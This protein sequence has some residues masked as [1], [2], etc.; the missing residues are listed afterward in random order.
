MKKIIILIM[1]IFLVS[2]C[3]D[4]EELNNINIVTGIGFDKEDDEYLVTLEITKSMGKEQNAEKSST[5]FE[6][7]DKILEIAINK[8]INNSDKKAYFKHTNIILISE[9][10]AKDGISNII[11]Y[12]LRDGNMSTTYFT[13][14]CENASEILKMELEND[15]VSNLIVSTINSH[16][17]ADAINN[18]DVI[19]SNILNKRKDIALPYVEKKD[20][21]KILLNKKAYFNEDKMIDTINNKIYN[22]LFLNNNDIVFESNGN[23]LNIVDNNVKYDIKKDKIIVNITG[24]GRIVTLNKDN[25]IKNKDNYYE[26]EKMINKEIEKEINDFLDETLKNKSDL[27]GLDDLYYKKYH[28]EINNIN[29][30]IDSKIKVS[31]NGVLLE[32][33]HD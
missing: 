18:I 5:T 14:I 26:I 27:I 30:E 22:F 19:T 13:I 31:R 8:A 32:V 25:D 9:K 6:A 16:I 24:E 28:K 12:L 23:I 17:K 10:I 20:E 15:T 3:Y 1:I 7:K 21:D 33:I 11:D 29:Y 4:C 2:G